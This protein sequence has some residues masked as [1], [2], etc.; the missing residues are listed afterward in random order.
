MTISLC[1]P[2]LYS[3]L[4]EAFYLN[5]C[6]GCF[7]PATLKALF[8]IKYFPST[9]LM[10]KT[11]EPAQ[12]AWECFFTWIETRGCDST[13]SAVRTWLTTAQCFMFPSLQFLLINACM[14]RWQCYPVT[15]NETI[16]DKQDAGFS[17]TKKKI[18]GPLQAVYRITSKNKIKS[19]KKTE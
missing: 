1:P 9:E 18:L 13:V 6:F 5:L 17:S 12:H 15:E 16:T 14:D 2:I 3:A 19:H 11:P 10:T 8:L 4:Q 7:I